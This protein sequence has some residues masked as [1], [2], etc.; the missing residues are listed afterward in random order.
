MRVNEVIRGAQGGARGAAAPT[1]AF[2]P[3]AH[4]TLGSLVCL[5]TGGARQTKKLKVAVY[6]ETLSLFFDEAA[7]GRS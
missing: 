5:G 1:W 7:L 3:F 4:L 6:R 2:E